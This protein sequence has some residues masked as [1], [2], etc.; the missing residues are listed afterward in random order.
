MRNI[1]INKDETYNHLNKKIKLN[2]GS[3]VFL[4]EYGKIIKVFLVTSFRDGTGKYLGLS[5]SEYCSLLD[6]DNGQIIFKERCSRDT[7]I[8]RILSHILRL[9]NKKN[10]NDNINDILLSTK[11]DIEVYSLGSYILD[12]NIKGDL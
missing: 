5:T 10:V 1:R 7:T 9:N 2:N 11:Y 8:K 4:K 3:L 12:I 6:L